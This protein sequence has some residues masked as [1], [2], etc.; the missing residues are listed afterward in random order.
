MAL[1]SRY[2]QYSEYH[3]IMCLK[4]HWG[5]TRH[6]NRGERYVKW[7]RWILTRNKRAQQSIWSVHQSH[8]CWTNGRK[9]AFQVMCLWGAPS[10]L[11]SCWLVQRAFF[12]SKEAIVIL[13]STLW[14]HVSAWHRF[15]KKRQKC[16]SSKVSCAAFR[17]W[18]KKTIKTPKNPSPPVIPKVKTTPHEFNFLLSGSA[19][20]Q[21]TI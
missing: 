13:E 19:C 14:T 6:A 18:G 10:E 3:F 4:A 15:I 12:F 2:N 20:L 5:F 16:L 7:P 11:H 8:V 1:G 21:H 9:A 17:D